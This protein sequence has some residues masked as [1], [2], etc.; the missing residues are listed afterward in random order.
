MTH[1]Y[2]DHAVI[3]VLTTTRC[4]SPPRIISRDALCDLYPHVPAASSEDERE[5]ECVVRQRNCRYHILVVIVRLLFRIVSI[6]VYVFCNIPRRTRT[7]GGHERTRR[8][9][10]LGFVQEIDTRPYC[11]LD[12]ISCVLLLR[13]RN[14]REERAGR[15]WG[16]C[17]Q[18]W[19]VP[20]H[21]RSR[22]IMSEERLL[23]I[24]REII[25]WS[26]HQGD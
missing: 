14:S 19:C 1:R 20:N 8:S 23:L 24:R 15:R 11:K 21:T 7:D 5:R 26:G 18:L 3:S 16:L 9:V 25:K 6:G 10:V 12:G 4:Y 2:Y 13:V 22:G 17:P